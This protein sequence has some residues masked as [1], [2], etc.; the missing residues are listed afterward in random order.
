MG[1]EKSGMISENGI[2]T[3]SEDLYHSDPLPTPSL[4]AS[5]AKIL[6]G[7]SPRH[8]WQAHPRLNPDWKA[9][10]ESKFDFG[11]VAH[12]LLLGEGREVVVVN[13]NDWR[14]KAAQEAR[15][16]ARTMGKTPILD[17][18][19][20]TASAMHAAA[21]H[22]LG[23]IEDCYDA[24]TGTGQGEAVLAWQ[25]FDL[26]GNLPIWC[27]GKVD[28]LAPR[29]PTGHIVIY[30]YKSSGADVSPLGISRHLYNM[31]YEVPCA[32]YE[33]GLEAIH[34]D[35]AGK[36]IMRFV[37]QETEPPYL[38]QVAEMDAG[39]MTIG[40]KKV[41]Y[42]IQMWRRCLSEGN[43][44]GYPT[45]IVRADMPAYLENKWLEREMGEEDSGLDPFMVGSA[46]L[47][48]PPEKKLVMLG[49][50]G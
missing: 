33:R 10:E 27:R 26:Q 15:D 25:E 22:Q 38:L 2:Y 21:L 6:L 3:V 36:I 5:L 50:G 35:A 4:S 28:W 13:A 29:R 1:K 9:E 46:W 30:D 49:E 45:R 18:D 19:F 16:D 41:S 11:T 24:F 8:A 48:K 7:K 20:A 44:P 23:K 31:E 37:V 17:K 47:P 32:M 14:T 43:W 39:G 40:R 34:G 42:A 12:K